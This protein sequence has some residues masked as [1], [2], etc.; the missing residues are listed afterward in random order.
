[1]LYM[2]QYTKFMM[3]SYALALVLLCLT[4]VLFT[5]TNIKDKY[6]DIF[7]FVIVGITNLIGSMLVAKKIKQKGIV[8]GLIFGLIYFLL[9]YLLS[10][11]S[12]GFVINTSVGIYLGV[13]LLTGI[14]GGILGVNI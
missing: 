7:V 9:I 12:F 5:Y 4:A 11:I 3:L 8:V 6:L 13:A 14:L 10:G 1:M 2:R